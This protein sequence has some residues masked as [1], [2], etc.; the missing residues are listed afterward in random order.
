MEEGVPLVRL[1]NANY[2]EEGLKEICRG[3]GSEVDC[4]PKRIIADLSKILGQPGAEAVIHYM[5]AHWK[6]DPKAVIDGLTG[7]F[8]GGADVILQQMVA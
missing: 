8:H 7:I 5:P 1:K 3:C 2:Y 6:S 4:F